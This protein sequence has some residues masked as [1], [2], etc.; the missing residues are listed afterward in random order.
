MTVGIVR[1]G[2][3][4]HDKRAQQNEAPSIPSE[5]SRVLDLK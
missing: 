3:A 2:S 5:K 1:E 4:W